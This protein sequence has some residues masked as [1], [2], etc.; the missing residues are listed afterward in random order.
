MKAVW[1]WLT[2][3]CE[4]ADDVDAERAAAAL[5]GGGLEVESIETIGGD[6]SGVVI[7]EVVEKRKHPGAD[8][9][10]LVK[11]NDGSAGLTEVVCGAPNVPEPGGRVLWA[12]PGARLPN[13][14]DIAT[15][16]I[17]GV[18]SKGMLCSE[19]ELGL[20]DNH[21]GII[22]LEPGEQGAPLGAQAGAALGL[23]DVVL[24]IGI[25][26]NRS[27]ALGH[28]GLARELVAHLG[29]RLVRPKVDLEALSDPD[30]ACAD[31]V[32]VSIA[33][34]E[35]CRRYIARV[36]DGV[37]ASRSPRWM[38]R[39]LEMVGVRPLSNLV[40]VTN[41]VMF[42]TGQP[43]HAFDYR[44][45]RGQRIDVRLARAGEKMTTLDDVERVLEPD[46]LLICDGEGPVALAG[47]M[48]GLESEVAADTSR[49]LLE[50]AH[51]EPAGVRRTGRRLGLASESSYRFERHV[52]PN[53]TGAASIRAAALLAELGGGRI[54]TGAVDAYVRVAEPTTVTMR[55]SRASLVTGVDISADRAR[56]LLGHLGLEVERS[57]NSDE[58][59]VTVPTS[60]PDL[61]R[62]IDLIE[63]VLR[64]HGFD[65][66]PATLPPL[67]APPSRRTDRRPEIARQVLIGAGLSEAITFAWCA[68]A[69]IE[70]LGL[71]DSDPRARP[72]QVAN[73][74]SAEQGAMRTTLLPNLLSA[75]KHN[76][77]HQVA[78]VGLFEIGSVFL[79]SGPVTA[80]ALP[81][82]PRRVAAVLAGVGSGHLGDRRPVDVFD[83]KGILDHLLDALA[84]R[85][86]F[87]PLTDCPYLHPGYA[88][89]LTLPS[90]VRA[91]EIGEIHPRVLEA[92]A[93][94]QPVYAFELALDVIDQPGF[95]QMQPIARYPAIT[96]DLS[97]FVEAGVTAERVRA[98]IEAERQAL[99]ESVEVLEDYR[100]PERVPA[101]QKGMLWS[102]TYRAGDRTLTDGEVDRA[103]EALATHLL[104]ALSATRR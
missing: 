10:T 18:E 7:A 78:D 69:A 58:L 60:R 5:T 77:A 95:A 54:A 25:P 20:G 88:A 57:A 38:R 12:R 71:P 79:A 102:L 94:E 29:G 84:A 85:A 11:V 9:L 83:L 89:A 59:S 31:L 4:L 22:V 103:H 66:V 101:G 50:A 53:G 17:K 33:E 90:G 14:F 67:S 76:L 42:E 19:S 16:K 21:D 87:A 26:A 55:A 74:M 100:D 52:D 15:R 81:D 99:L 39:R 30:L 65:Q 40:D 82:E 45:V 70:H 63:E 61:G 23:R 92:Y 1:S 64:L 46:D 32:S 56:E 49:V 43:L 28:L 80:T 75:V 104:D 86:V 3:L 44:Q 27:D 72:I 36:I 48:G 96:R 24:D 97:F 6:F 68:G 34:P 98:I 62:E 2:E 8:K 91:G 51:F 93:I 47:V 37:S 13:G 35:R 41:Y 73:P